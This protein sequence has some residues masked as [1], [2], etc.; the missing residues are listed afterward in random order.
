MQAAEDAG[1]AQPLAALGASVLRGTRLIQTAQFVVVDIAADVLLLVL[2]HF[3]VFS[4]L[5]YSRLIWK[6]LFAAIRGVLVK[7]PGERFLLVLEFS[8][9]NTTNTQVVVTKVM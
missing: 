1:V 9:C 7:F 5:G 3:L 2:E 6:L 8:T 4:H